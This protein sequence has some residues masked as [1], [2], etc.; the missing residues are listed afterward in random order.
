MTGWIWLKIGGDTLEGMKVTSTDQ[1]W[2]K[3]KTLM[4]EEIS[5]FPY[6]KDEKN[7]EVIKTW[8]FLAGCPRFNSWWVFFSF[9]F[10]L[11]SSS[12]HGVELFLVRIIPGKVG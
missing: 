6:K 10:S 5:N 1:N 8:V 12:E 2:K 11:S 4:G 9:S 3:W 7:G